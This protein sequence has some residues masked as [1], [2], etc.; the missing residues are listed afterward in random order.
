[1]TTSTSTARPGPA[2]PTCAQDRSGFRH[3]TIAAATA[4]GASLV[5][6][7]IS[8]LADVDL[9]VTSGDGTSTIGWPSVLI[10]SAVAAAIGTATLA[11]L[12]R[13]LPHGRTIGFWLA[14]VV[15]VLSLVAG[16]I[17]ATTPAAAFVLGT[18]YAVVWG[19]VTGGSRRRC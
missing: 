9:V 14:T 12:R 7:A 11:F 1:M 19:A 15:F 6:W 8:Q 18:M 2:G 17:H 3:T 10:A 16:P 5:V 4:A 13:R